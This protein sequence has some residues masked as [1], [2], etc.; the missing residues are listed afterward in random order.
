[1]VE[2]RYMWRNYNIQRR[3]CVL[4]YWVANGFR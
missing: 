2:S 3:C 4:V 1:M